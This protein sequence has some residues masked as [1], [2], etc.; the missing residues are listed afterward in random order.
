[1]I[2]AGQLRD[3][4][5]FE[6]PIREETQWGS[7]TKEYYEVFRCRAQR[8]QQSLLRGDVSAKELFTEQMVAFRTRNY[9]K[10]TYDC[11]VKWAGCVWSV[12]MIE[13]FGNELTLTLKKIDV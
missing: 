7:E 6:C 13:P 10:I 12:N 2:R 9:P 4:L 3:M 5:V 8:K 1:M 11:R